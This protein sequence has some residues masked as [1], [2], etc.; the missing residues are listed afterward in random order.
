MV[1]LVL[2]LDP[3]PE[4]DPSSGLVSVLTPEADPGGVVPS[5]APEH[6]TNRTRGRQRAARGYIQSRIHELSSS[7]AVRD[8]AQCGRG[9]IMALAAGRG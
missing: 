1:G 8:F 3:V 7:Q 9:P 4:L 6:A 5:S 2:V